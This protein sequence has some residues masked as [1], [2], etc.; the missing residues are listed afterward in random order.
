MA[1]DERVSS[2]IGRIYESVDDAEQWEQLLD[3]VRTTLGLRCLMQSVADFE[4]KGMIR[5]TVIGEPRRPDGAEDY[6]EHAFE[7]DP[8]FRWAIAHPRAGFCDTEEIVP[9][10]G[11]IQ[12]DFIQ[13][14][15]NEWIG[16]T[17]WIVGYT[18]PD[19][20]LIFGLSAHPWAET[21]P[22]SSDNK[23]LFKM[24][25]E[26][27]KRAVR[28]ATR[29]PLF[30]SAEQALIL[31]DRRGRIRSISPAAHALLEDRDGLTVWDNQLHAPD[32]CSSSRLT[33]AII[34]ALSAL[35]DGGF[36]GAVN[37]SRPSGK[38]DLLVT[39]APL[40]GPRS[41]FGAFRP[42]ALVRIIDPE[43]R[44]ATSASEQWA[45]L[46]GFSPA[47]ARFAETLM[48]GDQNLRYA[49]D[50]LGITYATARVHLKHLLEKTDT[51]SQG[52]LARLLT[53]VG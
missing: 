32:S 7:I 15:F 44:V 33:A 13:W 48:S 8:S 6:Q 21:G 9:K 30:T 40:L 49:A 46:F 26:H 1:L 12:Q 20:E 51:H 10:E 25:F 18:A 39:V 29:P 27:I 34:S 36:G 35:D 16:S 37:L 41:T 42:V 52:Q 19:D 23:A 45:A 4:H 38:R 11:Y 14:N 31:L 22:L 28:L 43:S 2:L 24:L 50:E 3:D 17:H 53:R 47:E 5:S